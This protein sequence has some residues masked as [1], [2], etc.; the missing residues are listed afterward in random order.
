MWCGINVWICWNF[1]G[2]RNER[3]KLKFVC[4]KLKSWRVNQIP[5]HWKKKKK[6]QKIDYGFWSLSQQPFCYKLPTLN[7]SQHSLSLSLRVFLGFV[8]ERDSSLWWHVSNYSLKIVLLNILF[9][10]IKYLIYIY[11]NVLKNILS[12]QPLICFFFWLII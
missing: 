6:Q 5:L 3:E 4:G 7:F 12:T 10:C 8:E 11:I 2:K 1:D 9:V